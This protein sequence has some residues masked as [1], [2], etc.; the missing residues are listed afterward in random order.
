V[1]GFDGGVVLRCF[2]IF[3]VVLAR[4][5]L[6]EDFGIVAVA[7]V[8]I[9]FLDIFLDAGLGKAQFSLMVK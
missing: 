8:A 3:Y 9:N 5:L 1:V 6:P 2:S 7:L 4:L